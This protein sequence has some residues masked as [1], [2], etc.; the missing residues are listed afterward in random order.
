MGM[1]FRNRLSSLLNTQHKLASENQ[2]LTYTK[3]EIV[4]TTVVIY[5]CYGN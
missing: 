1:T 3:Q 5:F 2:Q 4:K